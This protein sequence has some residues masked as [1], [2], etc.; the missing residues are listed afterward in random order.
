MSKKMLIVA[1][2]VVA[3]LMGG[4]GAINAH[5][6][7]HHGVGCSEDSSSDGSAHSH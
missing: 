2:T 7:D 4:C 3:V 5:L 6:C 1:V